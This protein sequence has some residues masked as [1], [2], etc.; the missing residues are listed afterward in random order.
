M[1]LGI[2]VGGTNTDVVLLDGATVVVAHKSPTTHDVTSGIRDGITE[3]LKSHPESRIDAV[4]IGTTHFINAVTQ[5]KGLARTASIRLATPPQTI[6]PLT[7]WPQQLVD[8]CDAGTHIIRGGTQFDGRPLDALD[9]VSLRNLAR[10][11]ADD[12]I[13]HVAITGT[14][15]PINYADE[16][17]ASDILTAAH[18][19][20]SVSVSHEI[21]R[22]G[23][24]GREN[25]TILNESLRPLARSV[26]ASFAEVLAGLS[27]DAPVFIT[28]NEGTLMALDQAEKYPIFAIGSGPTNSMRG[29]STLCGLDQHD[30][31]IVVDVGGTTTD[32]GLLRGGFPRESTV[33][34]NLGGVRSN[35]RMPDVSSI[36]IGGG[37]IVDEVTGAVGPSSVGFRLTHEA[38]VFGGKTLT[39]TDIAV[40]AGLVEIGDVQAVR[41]IPE[42]L[43]RLALGF[44][45]EKINALIEQTKLSSDRVTV[46]VV[47]GGAPLIAPLIDDLTDV[48]DQ[49]GSANALGAAIAMAGGEVD[50]IESLAG[51]SSEAI[52]AQ[53]RAD[54]Q[55]RTVTAGADPDAVRIIDEEYIPLSHLPGGTAAR[56]RVRAVGDMRLEGAML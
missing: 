28:S 45:R 27:V 20:L 51:T 42:S 6:M 4:V 16:Q 10:A 12:G 15:S 29:A 35:F 40:A 46:A 36:G 21:G 33:A 18:P 38:H 30:A 37:S 53:A 31:A 52:M 5:A 24:L 17:R 49:P 25:S 41:D 47:G 39:L 44:V 9:E 55:E 11:F 13:D 32:I 50:R 3:V 14:F 19:G 26:A 43:V 48:P 8:A 2:D 34:V 22:V 56:V 54:A 23:I 7:D 1:R